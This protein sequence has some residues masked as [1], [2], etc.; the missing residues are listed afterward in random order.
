LAAF[1]LIIAESK[2]IVVY[3]VKRFFIRLMLTMKKN[4][5]TA[6]NQAML[7]SISATGLNPKIGSTVPGAMSPL[8]MLTICV[9][10]KI[11]IATDCIAGGKVG[12]V[13]GKKVPAKK[14]MGVMNRNDG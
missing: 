13:K 10:G 3:V 4:A 12:E 1:Y 2:G 11:A 9:S 7:T 8:E 5:V 14:S 6:T